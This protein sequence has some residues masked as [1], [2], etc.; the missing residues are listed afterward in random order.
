MSQPDTGAALPTNGHPTVQRWFWPG[1]FALA[2]AAAGIGY[3]EARPSSAGQDTITSGPDPAVQTLPDP[4]PIEPLQLGEPPPGPDVAAPVSSA[5][6]APDTVPPAD[7]PVPTTPSSTSPPTTPPPATPMPTLPPVVSTTSMTAGIPCT[8]VD[9]WSVAYPDD[10]YTA[11]GEWAC[12][13]FAPWPIVIEEATEVD[14]AIFALTLFEPIDQALQTAVPDNRELL[15]WYETDVGGIRAVAV[16]LEELDDAFYSAG[17]II[18]DVYV[19]NGATTVMFETWHE[20]G[21]APW[22]GD[23]VDKLTLSFR[24]SPT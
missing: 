19:D 17:T 10:W 24:P 23:V 12:T 3:L 9:G 14:V 7:Q 16:I 11:G 15:D 22:Y 20:G 21:D 18:Y 4:G 5:P 13:A 8:S 2:V 1:M 6:I